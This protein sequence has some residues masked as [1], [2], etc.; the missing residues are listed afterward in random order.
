MAAEASTVSCA[1]WPVGGTTRSAPV[2]GPAGAG[3]GQPHRS[4]PAGFDA[5]AADAQDA[6]LHLR[7][8]LPDQVHVV[9]GD[10]DRLAEPVQLHEE[11]EELQGHL[12]V[13]VAGGLVG[14]DDVGR[15]HDRAGERRALAFAARQLAAGTRRRGP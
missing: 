11:L 4:A 15:A 14:E 3:G 12:P 7:L 2:V 13:D 1:V 6:G 8:G 10:D 9:G 5:A